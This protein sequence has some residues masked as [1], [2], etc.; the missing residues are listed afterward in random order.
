MCVI[1]S[2]YFHSILCIKYILCNLFHIGHLFLNPSQRH[3]WKMNWEK[4]Q[5]EVKRIPVYLKNMFFSILSVISRGGGGRREVRIG[6]EQSLLVFY[7][8]MYSNTH[9]TGK[10]TFWMQICWEGCWILCLLF[11]FQFPSTI[12]WTIMI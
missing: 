11:F 10:M 1:V 6:R 7:R 3:W 9:G 4:C 5:R 12:K 8:I 2:M